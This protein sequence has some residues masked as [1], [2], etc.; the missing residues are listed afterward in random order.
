VIFY[1]FKLTFIRF[2]KVL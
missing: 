1:L 2:M